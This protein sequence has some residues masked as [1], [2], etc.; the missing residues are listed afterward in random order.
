M[1]HGKSH[2]NVSISRYFLS[3]SVTVSLCYIVNIITNT[4]GCQGIYAPYDLEL[5]ELALTS[6]CCAA[7]KYRFAWAI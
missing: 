2:R 4:G 5:Y 7:D 1:K 3:A 6:A